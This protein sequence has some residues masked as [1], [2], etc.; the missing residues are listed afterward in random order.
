LDVCV[1]EDG[2]DGRRCGAGFSRYFF[3]PA[4]Q[5]MRM[6]TGATAADSPSGSAKVRNFLPSAEGR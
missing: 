3:K 5:F 4:C 6:V 1:G 2:R